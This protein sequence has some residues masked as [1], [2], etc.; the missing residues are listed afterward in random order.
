MA[1]GKK[2]SGTTYTSKGQRPNVSKDTTRKMSQETSLLDLN[3][4]KIRAL[5]KGKKVMV[6]IPNPNTAETNKPFIRVPASEVWS[7]TGAFKM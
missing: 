1:K 6:T 5:R 2:S 4:N 7:Q 3:V